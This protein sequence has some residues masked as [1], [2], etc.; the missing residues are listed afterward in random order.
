MLLETKQFLLLD[1]EIELGG[2]G[3]YKVELFF[4]QFQRNLGLQ[5]VVLPPSLGPLLSTV[6]FAPSEVIMVMP[7][8][9][10]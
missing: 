10:T 6:P 2:R 9:G 8:Y 5:K 7:H 4:L 3:G 1:C